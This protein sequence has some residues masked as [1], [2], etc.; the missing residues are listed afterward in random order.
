MPASLRKIDETKTMFIP[1][2]V[3]MLTEVEE[4]MDTWAD[5]K[6]EEEVGQTDPY[7]TA[8]SS[9]NRLSMEIGEKTIMPVCTG[10]IQ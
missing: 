6:D 3:Q 7:H 2:L 4:D 8:V 9:I 1:A 5:Q 10:M